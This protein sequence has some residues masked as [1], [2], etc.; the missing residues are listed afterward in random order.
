MLRAATPHLNCGFAID[1]ATAY[2]SFVK[3]KMTVPVCGAIMLNRARDRVLLVKGWKAAASWSFPR[4]KIN[5]GER[6]RDCAV[7]EVWE[8]CGYDLRPHFDPSVVPHS[9]DAPDAPPPLPVRPDDPNDDRADDYLE[10]A[11]KDGTRQRMRLYIV[12]DIDEAVV[13]KTRTR[14]EISV[15]RLGDDAADSAEHR[16]VRHSRPADGADGPWRLEGAR[17]GRGRRGLARQVLHGRAVRSV[18]RAKSGDA[19]STGRS[20]RGSNSVALDRS[21]HL[22]PHRPLRPPRPHSPRSTRARARS[23]SSSSARRSLPRHH[24]IRVRRSSASPRPVR[25]RRRSRSSSGNICHPR[26]CPSRST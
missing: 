12:P 13:F 7:R 5:Q 21:R 23:K 24:A 20:R 1:P 3:Y 17:L 19:D 4:G 26:A 8:E 22:S 9:S 25:R 16:L 14:R 15:R 11:A 6:D 18:R 2:D 10:I